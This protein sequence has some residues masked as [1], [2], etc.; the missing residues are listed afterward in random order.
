MVLRRRAVTELRA[1]R[2]VFARQNATRFISPLL[3]PDVTA[4]LAGE[5]GRLGFR[6]RAEGLGSFCG[7][8]LP[9]TVLARRTKAEFNATFFNRHSHAFAERWSGAGVDP[10]LVD[11]DR[12]RSAW[13]GP[14]HYALSATLLQT[15]WLA[16]D[17]RTSPADE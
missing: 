7:D 2:E 4:A 3:E 15:A 16:D 12:L 14:R 6:D 11:H 5:A 9:E 17:V 1:N 10:D 13:R 8:L